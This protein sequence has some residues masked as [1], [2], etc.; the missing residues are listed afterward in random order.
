MMLSIFRPSISIKIILSLVL[1]IK[2]VFTNTMTI[3]IA[4]VHNVTKK[5]VLKQVDRS[6]QF[7]MQLCTLH[8]VGLS[9]HKCLCRIALELSLYCSTVQ[10]H[11]TQCF[12]RAWY[13]VVMV[14]WWLLGS[15]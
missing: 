11:L 4:N 5:I 9:V 15:R 14:A 2:V 12:H 13:M 7:V 8:K 6:L 10:V 1:V 3:T